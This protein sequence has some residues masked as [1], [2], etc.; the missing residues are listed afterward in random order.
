VAP[1]YL[2]EESRVN[3][4][5]VHRSTWQCLEARWELSLSVDEENEGVQPRLVVGLAAKTVRE[6]K[7]ALSCSQASSLQEGAEFD[8]QHVSL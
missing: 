8:C 3:R 5:L 4:R 6:D 2:A 1:S 7:V